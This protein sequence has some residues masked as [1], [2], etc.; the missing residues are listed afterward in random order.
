M[1][2]NC[3]IG[4]YYNHN[5]SF[6]SRDNFVDAWKDIMSYASNLKGNWP[7]SQL[8]FYNCIV[9][10]AEKNPEQFAG[11]IHEM[12]RKSNIKI[13]SRALY[14]SAIRC[15]KKLKGKRSSTGIKKAL[16]DL[17]ESGL[18]ESIITL[19]PVKN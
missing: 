16:Y 10:T 7:L 13:K 19:K 1:K 15:M 3:I 6:E 8:I 18:E 2:S 14:L 17:L 4:Y 11:W 9:P 12:V 5:E